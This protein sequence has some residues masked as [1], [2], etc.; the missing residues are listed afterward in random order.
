MPKVSVIVPVYN[1]SRYLHKCLDT[2]VNQTYDDY[3]VIIVND[4]STDRSEEIIY[5]YTKSYSK[6]RYFAKQNEGVALARNYGLSVATGE[7]IMFVDSDD[8]VA[9]NIIEKLITPAMASN[10]DIVTADIVKFWENGNNEYYKTNK[11]YSR[12]NVRNYIIGDSGPCSKLFKKDIISQIPF[13]PTAYEDLDI[14]PILS[15]YAYRIG[16]VPEGLYYYRQVEGSATRLTEFNESMLDIFTVLD[17]VYNRLYEKY[18]EEV[19]Y[20]YITHLLRTSTLRF[21]KFKGTR[22]HLDEIVGVMQNRFPKWNKNIYFKKSSMKLKIICYLAYH[23]KFSLI[24]W[25]N[26]ITKK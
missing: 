11:E 4:G 10:L 1:A 8:Y 18:P 13:R 12:D 2:L 25:V 26:K 14:I 6:L 20:L 24:K 3:E 21:L 5:Q 15:L 9:Y 16:Y 22:R 19:E 23:K 17:N 7:Y